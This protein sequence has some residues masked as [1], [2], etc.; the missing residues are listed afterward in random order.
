MSPQVNQQFDR[1]VRQGAFRPILRFITGADADDRLQEGISQTFELALRKAAR[2]EQMD[3][4][5]VVYATRLRATD[6]RRRFV[7]GGQP[8]RDA[9]C[10]AN[11]V[12]GRVQVLHIDGLDHESDGWPRDGDPGLQA[13]WSA[14]VAVDPA[15]QL[16]A[17]IDLGAWLSGLEAA[18]RELLAG[19]LAGHTLQELAWRTD[20]SVTNLFQRLRQ[21]GKSLAEHAGIRIARK[22]R[23]PR[24]SLVPVA[25][26][27]AA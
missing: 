8:R 26:T 19:R 6:I 27:P 9:L 12:D 13:A 11:F 10:H 20:R 25:A 5:L 14:A 16:A 17:A 2:G 3:D 18:D 23:K 7:K 22:P 4:P 24:S 21:L 1:L 15:E